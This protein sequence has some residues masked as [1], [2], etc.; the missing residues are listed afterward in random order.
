M[1]SIWY[2]L[3]A[4]EWQI[5]V[6]HTGKKG[7]RNSRGFRRRFHCSQLWPMRDQP[8]A[9]ER[10]PLASVATRFLDKPVE[11]GPTVI[12]L[13]CGFPTKRVPSLI[14][15]YVDLLMLHQG[16]RFQRAQYALLVNGLTVYR[17]S[18]FILPGAFVAY[19]GVWH[20]SL[21]FYASDARFLNPF[22]DELP[23]YCPDGWSE[24]ICAYRFRSRVTR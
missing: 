3:P 7:P 15:G 18:T 6:W 9:V 17:H 24:S 22:D 19:C 23:N 4:A 16:K 12:R 1:K 10:N 13:L 5:V 11:F 20:S 21:P 2:Q 14:H 8:V